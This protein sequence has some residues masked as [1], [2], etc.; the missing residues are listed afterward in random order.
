MNATS[1]L[2]ATVL[3]VFDDAGWSYAEVAG[4]EVVK[5]G[6]E[7]HHARVELHVQVFAK[8]SAVSVV[9]ESARRSP[10]PAHRER[11]AELAMR[12]NQTLTVGNFELDWDGGRLCF[13]VTNLFSSPQGDP[14]ILRGL[15][16]TTVGEMDRIAP[17]EAIV[18]GAEG[19]ALASL[20]LAS[21]LQRMDLLPDVPAP[22]SAAP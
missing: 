6:F 19:P 2:H 4:R 3:A 21:L 7:A 12:V 22:A 10:G 1:E 5:A 15:I 11:L 13:R 14:A 20:D 17:L 9:S 18:L 8:L 16:H